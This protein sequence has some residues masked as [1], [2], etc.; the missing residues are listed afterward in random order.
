[1]LTSPSAGSVW[2]N[3]ALLLATGFGVGRAPRAPGTFGSLLGVVVYLAWAHSL[4][5]VEY[6]GLVAA[7]FLAGIWLCARA[8][9]ALG[10]HDSPAIVWD[11]I[12][13][14]LCALSVVRPGWLWIV[15]AFAL[16]RLFDIWKPFPI[17]WLNRRVTGGLGIMADDL[18]AGLAAA[19][20]LEA[21]AWLTIAI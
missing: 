16:F 14:Q 12:V 11:E 10:V 17:G 7:L 8:E 5:P 3:P 18:A 19:I 6:A 9:R 4:R 20:V 21:I 13:G 1:M 2:R 15:L